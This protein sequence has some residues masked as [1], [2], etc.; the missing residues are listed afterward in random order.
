VKGRVKQISKF[1]EVAKE[2]RALHNF[3]G[4]RSV[5]V[6]VMNATFEGDR[7][8]ELFQEG[9]PAL[10]KVLLAYTRL[11]SSAKSYGTYRMAFK[12][13]T[14]A[15]IPDTCVISFKY[16]NYRPYTLYSEVHTYDIV[17]LLDINPDFNPEDRTKIH[18]GKFNA[19]GK[20][21]WEIMVSKDRCLKSKKY[22]QFPIREEVRECIIGVAPMTTEVRAIDS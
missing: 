22:S 17:R 10:H 21:I 18:W 6:G 15:S 11:F 9:S 4:V 16:S 7:V 20:L 3:A 5:T 12:S 13:M 14:R 8:M 1:V 19:A 2:L